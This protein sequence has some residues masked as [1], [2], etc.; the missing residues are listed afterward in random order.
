VC[1]ELG[2]VDADSNAGAAHRLEAVLRTVKLSWDLP[3][4]GQM[5]G[6]RFKPNSPRDD[7]DV[8]QWRSR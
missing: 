2:G 5:L 4:S 7:M 6:L 3:N 8:W 1:C